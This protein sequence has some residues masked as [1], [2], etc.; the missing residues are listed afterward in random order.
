MIS[1]K[2]MG[3]IVS[4]IM[5]ISLSLLLTFTSSLLLSTEKSIIIGSAF[6]IIT[7]L[8]KK[9][10]K[11]NWSGLLTLL[12]IV[13]I[14]PILLFAVLMLMFFLNIPL[15]FFYL[16]SVVKLTWIFVTIGFIIGIPLI[17]IIKKSKKFNYAL[18]DY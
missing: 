18:L 17:Q 7:L 16:I 5:L 8:L 6:F 4:I 13:F 11:L 9:M 14:T 10:L 2:I 12:S 15:E 1:K 3:T